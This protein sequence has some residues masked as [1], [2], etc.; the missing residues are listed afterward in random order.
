MIDVIEVVHSI[1]YPIILLQNIQHQQ[2]FV[3]PPNVTG[4]LHMFAMTN[5]VF[6]RLALAGFSQS[7]KIGLL[8][9]TVH[10]NSIACPF[11]FYI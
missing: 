11:T 4:L 9:T 2:I 1:I 8:L 6:C 10:D 5:T 7:T 3:Q